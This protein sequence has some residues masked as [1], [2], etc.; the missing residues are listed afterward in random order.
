[1]EEIIILEKENLKISKEK[2]TFKIQFKSAEYS[3]INSLIKTRIIQGGSTDETYKI[4]IFNAKS[5][6]TL[7]QFRNERKISEGRKN[8]SVSDVSKMIRS[9]VLQLNNLVDSESH[10]IIGYNEEDII[11]I[12]DEKFPIFRQRISSKC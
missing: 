1:M 11:V 7:E 2:S 3:L 6:K 4:I 12:N 5:V 9:L 10:T 8:L